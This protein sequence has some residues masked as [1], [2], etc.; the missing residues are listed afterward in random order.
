MHTKLKYWLFIVG[1]FLPICNGFAFTSTI[2][3][4]ESQIQQRVI[5]A[6]PI[7]F[8]NSELSIEFY[9]PK[10]ILSKDR[11]QIILRSHA[12]IAANDEILERSIISFGGKPY[13]LAGKGEF[14][15]RDLWLRSFETQSLTP[16]E[17]IQLTLLVNMALTSVL[18]D[19]PIYTLNDNDLREKIARKRL[20]SAKVVDGA[21]ELEFSLD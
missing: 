18:L 20:K 19:I 5:K 3:L 13:Y 11:N 16:Q 14:R 21:L 10:V 6:F 12:K 1:L 9:R 4:S 2:T 17:E 15:L 8:G 7:N